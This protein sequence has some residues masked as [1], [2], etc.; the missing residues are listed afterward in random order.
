MKKFPRLWGQSTGLVGGIT[1][2]LISTKNGKIC[3]LFYA[4]FEIFP[5]NIILI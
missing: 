1:R 4:L 5:Q 2:G 3:L